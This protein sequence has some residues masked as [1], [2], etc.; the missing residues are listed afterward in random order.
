MAVDI[1]E[2][3]SCTLATIRQHEPC[4]AYA[5]R[6]VFARSTTPEWSGTTG[7]VYPAIAR[8]LKRGLITADPRA[9]D[10]RG[11]RDLR[12]TRQGAQAVLN[13]LTALEP[14]TAKAAPDPIR[15]RISFLDQLDS[16]GARI[17]LL[18]RAE[19]L[20]E[21]ALNELDI[22]LEALKSS[23]PTEYLA[24]LGAAAEVGARLTWLR[25]VLAFYRGGRSGGVDE[26]DL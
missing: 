25:Q 23:Q 2:F 1:T 3:E 16:D 15:T 6:Q 11:R 14:R 4:S 19:T 20:T 18:E 9:G 21:A 22:R 12:V 17:A 5:I 13:W 8:L 26:H 7:S 24:G 10:R